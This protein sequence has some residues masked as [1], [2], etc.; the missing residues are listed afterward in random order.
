[1]VICDAPSIQVELGSDARARL[2]AVEPMLAEVDAL[3]LLLERDGGAG[4]GAELDGN[5]NDVEKEHERRLAR[6]LRSQRWLWDGLR[7]F[8]ALAAEVCVLSAHRTGRSVRLFH[9]HSA[10]LFRTD[11]ANGECRRAARSCSI[12]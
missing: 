12:P 8:V 1:M 3:L 11:A 2:S 9:F 10:L 4:R 6:A 5:D 7:G